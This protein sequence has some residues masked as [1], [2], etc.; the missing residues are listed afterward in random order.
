MAAYLLFR[1]AMHNKD[2]L[3]VVCSV[4]FRGLIIATCEIWAAKYYKG[5]EGTINAFAWIRYWRLMHVAAHAAAS[6]AILAYTACNK[7]GVEDSG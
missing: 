1:G 5:G 2:W 6:T 3:V 7:A 4:L